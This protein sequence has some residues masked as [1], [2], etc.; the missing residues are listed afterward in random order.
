M[1]DMLEYV[2]IFMML[3]FF[4]CVPVFVICGCKK[5]YSNISDITSNS[6]KE[7]LIM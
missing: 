2:L 3:I 4:I 6:E 1:N 5:R 7:K